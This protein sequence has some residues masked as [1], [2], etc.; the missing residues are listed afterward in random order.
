MTGIAAIRKIRCPLALCVIVSISVVYGCS[1][2]CDLGIITFSFRSNADVTES[3]TQKVKHEHPGGSSNHAHKSHS[4]D[5]NH[6][7]PANGREDCCGDLTQ[8][9]YSSL[10]S[11]TVSAFALVHGEGFRLLH[12]FAFPAAWRVGP[13]NC[14]VISSIY[15]SHAN[16]P[17]G[18]RAANSLLIL[19]CTFVI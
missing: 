9:F 2:L 12:K 10:G 4:H 13:F 16:G 3:R 6:E 1:P 7:K 19:F 8:Q 14:P 17:P 15:F 5:A 11:A 18:I